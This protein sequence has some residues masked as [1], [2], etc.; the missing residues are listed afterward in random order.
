MSSSACSH[1]LVPAAGTSPAVG[2]K[3]RRRAL[4][5]LLGDGRSCGKGVSRYPVDLL[6]RLDTARRRVHELGVHLLKARPGSLRAILSSH[7]ALM[8][9]VTT[10]TFGLGTAQKAHASG[11]VGR[12]RVVRRVPLRYG[13]PSPVR[14]GATRGRALAVSRPLNPRCTPVRRIPGGNDVPDAWC[15]HRD[16]RRRRSV[17]AL[18]VGGNLAFISAPSGSPGAW[19]GWVPEPCYSQL[20][21]SR[22]RGN[23]QLGSGSRSVRDRGNASFLRGR[24]TRSGALLGLGAFVKLYPGLLV[25]PFGWS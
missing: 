21:R 24:D 3:V 2:S 23:A 19:N 8:L 1:L 25:I 9:I 16:R 17:L 13:Y 20:H 14:L 5:G 7:L 6:V 10:L 22:H 12:K 18:L 15:R 4:P 11:V